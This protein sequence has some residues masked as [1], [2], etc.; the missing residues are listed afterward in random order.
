VQCDQILTKLF[1]KILPISNQVNHAAA[2][3]WLRRSWSPNYSVLVSLLQQ[4]LKCVRVLA[5]LFVQPFLLAGCSKVFLTI[6]HC[7]RQKRPFRLVL[8]ESKK[9]FSLA[10]YLISD[11]YSVSA[12]YRIFGLRKKVK[13][14]FSVVV[15]F[16]DPITISVSQ[17][18]P[19][20][21]D[22]G[23][24][25]TMVT[26]E[27]REYCPSGIVK[28]E[29]INAPGTFTEGPFYYDED[30][31]GTL[32]TFAGCNPGRGCKSTSP[33]IG[34]TLF[35]HCRLLFLQRRPQEGGRHKA[36]DHESRP[37][38]LPK[39][40]AGSMPVPRQHQGRLSI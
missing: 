36:P 13:I 2:S 12:M 3:S 26:K 21:I 14:V 29:C 18:Y 15:I 11:E 17:D 39:E 7:T 5:K 40:R 6:G 23:L 35:T 25:L 31:I 30:P 1:D 10:K 28:C 8:D 34:C 9:L 33:A 38:R 37:G 20:D 24:F 22:P 32:L 16:S 19:Q 27:M 4:V